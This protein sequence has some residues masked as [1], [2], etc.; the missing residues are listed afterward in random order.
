MV[1]PTHVFSE[2]AKLFQLQ[3]SVPPFIT[4]M[5]APSFS[6]FILFYARRCGLF[7]IIMTNMEIII[8]DIIWQMDFFLNTRNSPTLTCPVLTDGNKN[9]GVCLCVGGGDV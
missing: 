3:P 2:H 6:H 9:R 1:L 4:D 7:Y 5:M 8:W